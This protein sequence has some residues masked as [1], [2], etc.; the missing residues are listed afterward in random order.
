MNHFGTKLASILD[1]EGRGMVDPSGPRPTSFAETSKYF[2][3]QLESLF[4]NMYVPVK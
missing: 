2:H 4:L 1:F 3:M